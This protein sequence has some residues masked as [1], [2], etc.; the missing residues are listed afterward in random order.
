[1]PIKIEIH[2]TPVPW[3]AS[4]ISSR[5][6]WDPRGKNKITSKWLVKIALQKIEASVPLHGYI[7]LSMVFYEP[8]PASTPKSKRAGMLDGSIRPTRCDTT[9]L[10]KYYEDCLK[11]ILFD[12]DRFVVKNISEKL[13]ADKGKILITVFSLEEYRKFYEDSF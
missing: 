2:E 13:Y 8:I 4:R 6:K 3:T 9:N 1:M 10:Q 12:D 5:G 7:V 11:N